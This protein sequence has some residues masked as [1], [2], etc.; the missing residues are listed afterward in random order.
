[1]TSLAGHLLVAPPTETDPDFVDTVILLIQHSEQQAVG[2]VLNR[3]SNKTINDIWTGKRKETIQQCVYSGGPVSGPLM[4]IHTHQ[5]LA[6]IEIIGG[7]YY[8]ARKNHVEKIVTVPDIC[9]KFFDGHVGWGPGQ[10]EQWLEAKG[11]RI[12]PATAKDVFD[13]GG[14]VG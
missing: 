9:C 6:E 12:L 10:L 4:A 8:S 2:V 11:F 3:P 5:P 1:M 13:A 14:C 7:V